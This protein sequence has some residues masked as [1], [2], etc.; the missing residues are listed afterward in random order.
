ML[1]VGIWVENFRCAGIIV[2]QWK[3]GNFAYGQHLYFPTFNLYTAPA[4]IRYLQRYSTDF[5][6][7]CFSSKM[8]KVGIWVENFRC[9]GVLPLKWQGENFAHRQHFKFPTFNLYTVPAKLPYLQRYT[10][11]FRKHWLQLQDVEGGHLGGKF[12]VRR[13]YCFAMERRKICASATF[14][15]SHFQPVHCSQ[16]K[17]YIFKGIQ[18]ILENFASPW[19][20]W[21]W[22][23]GSKISGARVFCFWNGKEKTLRIDNICTFP[24]STCTL[25]Q[26]KSYI[27][28]GIQP[29]FENVASASRWWRWA[30]GWKISCAQVL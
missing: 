1:K 3:G 13:Y 17:S 9:A 27:F 5:R 11:D 2:L 29:I 23:F 19:R 6:K 10:T 24:L 28:K 16:Q 21:R 7:L 12:Q 15:I 25:L 20:C 22:A 8:L 18:P 26:E 30:F 14:Q 4:K